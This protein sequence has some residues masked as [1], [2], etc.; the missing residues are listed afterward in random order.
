MQRCQEVLLQYFLQICFSL[1]K[2]PSCYLHTKDRHSIV[3]KSKTSIHP[4]KCTFIKSLSVCLLLCQQR[5]QAG[6]HRD[7]SY[8]TVNTLEGLTYLC[9]SCIVHTL[10][11]PFSFLLHKHTPGHIIKIY[12]ST[13]ENKGNVLWFISQLNA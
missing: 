3:V 9:H 5:G 11:K 4:L 12:H 1:S 7:F 13:T 8:N 2:L 10:N 6:N